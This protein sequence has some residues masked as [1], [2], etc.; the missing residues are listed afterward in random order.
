MTRPAPPAVLFV[1]LGNICR[2]PLAEAAFRQRATAAGLAC[3]VDSAGTGGWHAGEPPDPRAVAEAAR[4]GIDIAGYRA[5]QVTAADFTRF[6]HVY[7][8]DH[9][10][11]AGLRRLRPAG[12]PARLG[13]LLDCLPDRAGQPVADPYY[14]DA[15]G[16]AVTW[17]EVDRAA[18]ALVALLG[19]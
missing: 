17:A 6:S 4:H 7:A 5:R 8:L 10:N 13:L 12:S 3:R 16:F 1:C 18:R 9:D 2:S 11:L 19:A 15:A 14:G